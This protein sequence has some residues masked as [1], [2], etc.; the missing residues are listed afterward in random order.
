MDRGRS[1]RPPATDRYARVEDELRHDTALPRPPDAGS[2]GG[3]E[4]LQNAAVAAA[5]P[6]SAYVVELLLGW[7]DQVVMMAILMIFVVAAAKAGREGLEWLFV[8][9][10]STRGRS[11]SAILFVV[12]LAL[13]A[14]FAATI[15]LVLVRAKEV[16]AISAAAATAGTTLLLLMI[17]FT[18]GSVLV[19]MSQ[20]LSVFG[21]TSGGSGGAHRKEVEAT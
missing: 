18:L 14:S 17:A 2:G 11:R 10:E 7:T 15:G 4:M 19:C 8:A 13:Y 6:I 5:L 12:D 16:L 20:T 3:G 9:T 21:T 1:R